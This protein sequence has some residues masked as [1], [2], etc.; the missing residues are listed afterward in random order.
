MENNNENENIKSNLIFNNNNINNNY[1]INK[2]L[3]DNVFI[4]I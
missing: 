4:F 2:D 3:I 1:E